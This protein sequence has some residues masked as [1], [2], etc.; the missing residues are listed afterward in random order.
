MKSSLKLL[1]A[2][3]IVALTSTTAHA[4]LIISE[5]VDGTLSGGQPK[6]IEI[7]NTSASPV[8]MSLYKLVHYNNGSMTPGGNIALT[9]AGMLP[10]GASWVVTYGAVPNVQFATVY[11]HAADQEVT[12]GGHNGDDAIALELAVGGIVDVYGIIG[13]DPITTAGSCGVPPVIS[14]CGA[15]PLWD[16]EDGYVYR[17]GI[18]ASATF[19]PSDWVIGGSDSLED[20]VGGD[21]AR[22]ILLQSLTTP[23][24]KQ[25]CNA[26][27]T[28][29][30]SAKINSL[31]CSPSVGFV[32]SS[33]ATAGSGFTISAS[34]VIN[35]K[36][37]LL[38]YSNT[39]QAAVPF[40]GGVRCM[41]GPVRRSS[42]LNSAGNP[43]PNDCSGVYSIDMN[44]FAVGAL[45]GIPAGYLTI[46][47]TVVDAQFWGRDNG[48]PPPNNATLSNALEFTVGP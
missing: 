32:G 40:L 1:G 28:V 12:Y 18:T 36:P 39:G 22:I 19:V 31:G 7:S 30:C 14:A 16:Y 4:Q 29:Y 9:P 24:T 33:S 25:G 34:Q 23:G 48:F 38:I 3:A 42:A 2:A 11:G 21:P 5:I 35:N 44:A 45:G 27:P 20:C 8:D 37:G 13:C 46:A 47:G 10:A 15:S 17:C 6:F 43:P 41:N 26:V